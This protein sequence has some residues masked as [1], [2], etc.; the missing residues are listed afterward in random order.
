MSLEGDFRK[1]YAQT[2]DGNIIFTLPENANAN[3]ECK[4]SKRYRNRR[5]FAG[6]VSA[7][8]KTSSVWRIGNGGNNYRLLPLPTGRFSCAVQMI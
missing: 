6:G 3:I 5:N 7:T 1:I 8:K 4:S 2:G